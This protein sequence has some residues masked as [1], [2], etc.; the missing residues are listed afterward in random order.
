MVKIIK[1]LVWFFLFLW[2]SNFS[3]AE[4]LDLLNPVWTDIWLSQSISFWS[5]DEIIIENT[6]VV[7]CENTGSWFVNLISYETISD[8]SWNTFYFYNQLNWSYDTTIETP[9]LK[10]SKVTCTDE[11]LQNS[12]YSWTPQ[13]TSW[14]WAE[15]ITFMYQENNWAYVI[16]LTWLYKIFF[17]L[18]LIF[19]VAYSM[20][21][22]TI[23]VW[24]A[25]KIIKHK[26]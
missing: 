20:I 1:I 26:H 10:I 8:D 18:I 16:D 15:L 21:T 19:F 22:I 7:I 17:H 23:K 25:W 14:T 13:L 3:F 4:N 9:L 5:S 12:L 6:A 2:L 11:V 24:K